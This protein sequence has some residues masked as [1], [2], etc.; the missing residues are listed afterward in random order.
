MADNPIDDASSSTPEEKSD[1]FEKLVL[2]DD[3]IRGGAYEPPART[4]AA[5]ARYGGW[6]SS[7]RHS[8]GSRKPQAP[9]TSDASPGG[10]RRPR[11]RPAAR[12]TQ[13]ALP[14]PAMARLPLII[15]VVVVAI[16]AFLVFR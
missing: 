14:S 3:F 5:I 11:W 1:E 13:S 10:G 9:S 8:G 7:W 4:R 6:Q 16:A 12:P 15:T 2:D